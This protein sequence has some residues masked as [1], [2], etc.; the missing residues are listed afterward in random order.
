MYQAPAPVYQA[1]AAPQPA[2]KAPAAPVAPAPVYIAPVPVHGQASITQGQSAVVPAAIEAEAVVAPESAQ[3]EPEA[4]GTP[5]VTVEPSA[6]PVAT[7]ISEAVVAQGDPVAIEAAPASSASDNT[8]VIVGVAS[9]IV[10][11]GVAWMVLHFG[12]GINGIRG[13]ARGV[14]RR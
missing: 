3:G 6:S 11:G 8:P 12:P 7:P 5:T 4:T 13:I 1:P 2:Y 9:V 14:L 10:L